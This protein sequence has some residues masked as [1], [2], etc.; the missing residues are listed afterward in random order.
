MI[1]EARIFVHVWTNIYDERFL[2]CEIIAIFSILNTFLLQAQQKNVQKTL[3]HLP[4]QV[5][6]NR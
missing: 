6:T 1:G 2:L 5:S 3:R 4:T